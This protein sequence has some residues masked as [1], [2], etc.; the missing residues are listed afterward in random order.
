VPSLSELRHRFRKK[1]PQDERSRPRTDERPSTGTRTRPGAFAVSG[2]RQ[3]TP[4]TPQGK[5]VAVRHLCRV[6]EL[7]RKTI[8]KCLGAESGKVGLSLSTL[9]EFL[10]DL[11][12][13]ERPRRSPSDVRDLVRSF[14][15]DSRPHLDENRRV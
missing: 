1:P 8:L 4:E 5:E 12:A 3:V 6:A 9:I 13:R 15:Q 14:L 7:D 2:G 11:V 10:V